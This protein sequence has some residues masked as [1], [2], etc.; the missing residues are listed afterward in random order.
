MTKR[1]SVGSIFVYGVF[2]LLVLRLIVV[3]I[4]SYIDP[5]PPKYSEV[6]ELLGSEDFS[7]ELFSQNYDKLPSKKY[8]VNENPGI[9]SIRTKDLTLQV[10]VILRDGYGL[11]H[12]PEYEYTVEQNN[13]YTLY[14][15][16]YRNDG[17]KFLFV[18]TT[19]IFNRKPVVYDLLTQL[20]DDLS[21]E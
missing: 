3:Y 10:S 4:Y 6:M 15:C 8:T 14:V 5:L 21:T 2:A 11:T 18:Y 1:I 13:I 12:M 9:V 17:L 20:I 16:S 19:N 7:Y